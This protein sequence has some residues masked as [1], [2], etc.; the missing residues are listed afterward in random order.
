MNNQIRAVGAVLLLC[1]ATLFVRLNF[2]QVVDQQ[3]L[4]QHPENSRGPVADFGEARGDILTADGVVVATSREVDTRFKR[5][6]VYPEGELYAHTTGW[7]SFN[8]GVSGV[9]RAFSDQ[10]DGRDNDVEL[11]GFMDLFAEPD[12]RADVVL[13]IESSVQEAAADALGNRRGSVVALDPG[14]GAVVAAWSWP[15]F[16]PNPISS[17]DFGAALTAKQALDDDPSNPLLGRFHRD[18]FAP[19][20]TFKLVTAAAALESGRATATS[21]VFPPSQG[22]AAPIGSGNAIGNFGGSSCGG[23]M[24]AILRSS[25]NT[26]FAEMAAEMLGPFLMTDTA[27]AFGFNAEVPFDV[28]FTESS[29]FPDQYGPPLRDS[30]YNPPAPIVAETELVAQAGIG[31]WDV[32]ATPLQMALV[33]AGIANDGAVMTPHVMG[34]ITETETGAVVAQS[35]PSVWTQAV[36]SGTA[37]TLQQLMIGVVTDGTA[38][39]LNLDGLVVGGKTGT[40]QTTTNEGPDDT[41]AWIVAFA[42]RPGSDPELA[43]AV[44][45]EAVPG[46]GQQTGGTD[47]APVA[48]AVIEAFFGQ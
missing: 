12:E 38:K 45:V 1:F 30:R 19:G 33:A 35:Q 10:L 2:L 3:A 40:A 6:R 7:F 31:Q 46:G 11:D 44:M 21:P 4:A 39:A 37:A 9:E 20:S 13:T 8:L 25:C 41:H 24:G 22:Y 26:A 34:R 29:V 23:D 14:T 43:V 48:R 36:S 42:G 18:V 16:D 28:P 17:L 27:E 15:S 5:E 32:R 47:A